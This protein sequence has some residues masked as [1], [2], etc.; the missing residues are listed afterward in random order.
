MGNVHVEG[1]DLE[2]EKIEKEMVLL[3]AEVKAEKPR[4]ESSALVI[5]IVA[6]L[7]TLIGTV[8]GV[9]LEGRSAQ[10]LE[11]QRFESELILRGLQSDDPAERR[12]YLLFITRL[13]LL[14]DKDLELRIRQALDDST[15]VIPRLSTT[16][17]LELLSSRGN[18]DGEAG[19]GGDPG[20]PPPPPPEDPGENPPP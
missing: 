7:F 12:D 8:F 15:L 2:L 19:P 11:R 5:G 9:Y 6:A 1:R 17:I 4:K 20:E 16:D 3:R 14:A 18:M 10:E 13:G